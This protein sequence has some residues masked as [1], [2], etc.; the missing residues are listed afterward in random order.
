M[1]NDKIISK[2][3]S[4]EIKNNS[5]IKLPASDE[6]LL[7]SCLK[8]KY[9]KQINEYKNILEVMEYNKIIRSKEFQEKTYNNNLV[10]LNQEKDIKKNLNF[11]QICFD[12]KID[13][14][15]VPCGH[16]FCLKCI[17]SSNQCYFCRGTIEKK[18]RI[19]YS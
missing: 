17:E 11:C 12:N 5:F 16:L 19:I 1:K 4:V 13:T 3:L 14:V 6:K 9:K 2:N 7:F 10:I 18:Q 15:I 8:N